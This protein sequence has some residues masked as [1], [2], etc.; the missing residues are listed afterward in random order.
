MPKNQI[1]GLRAEPCP[2]WPDRV[3]FSV[4]PWRSPLEKVGTPNARRGTLGERNMPS[5]RR[6][7]RYRRRAEK[8]G[9]VHIAD[10]PLLGGVGGRLCGDWANA[11][12][13]DLL[14]L[15]KAIKEDWPV[16]VERRRP[17]LDAVFAQLSREDIS[18]RLALAIIQVAVAADMHDLELEEAERKAA[19]HSLDRRRDRDAAESTH[20][21]GRA[22]ADIIR[23]ALASPEGTKALLARTEAAAAALAAQSAAMRQAPQS[24]IHPSC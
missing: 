21:D 18:V 22:Q 14:L 15:R 5:R 23:A 9:F 16:P 6:R 12:R 2:R 17:L 1:A 7:K 8:H 13:S 4:G 3:V 11:S 10:N 20:A 19:K 24:P